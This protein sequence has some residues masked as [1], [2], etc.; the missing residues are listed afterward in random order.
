MKQNP[1]TK[2]FKLT[3]YTG[4]IGLWVLTTALSLSQDISESV[5]RYETT[6]SSI[7]AIQVSIAL[8]ILFIY[9]ALSFAAVTFAIYAHRITQSKE[10][11][12]YKDLASGL[13]L[14]IVGFIISA[15]LNA[16]SVANEELASETSFII[17]GNYA[18]ILVSIAIYW[19]FWRGSNKLL[20]TLKSVKG[21]A[22]KVMTGRVFILLASVIYTYLVFQNPYRT[23]SSDELI[24]PVFSLPDILIFLTIIIP[25]VVTWLL[26]I[27]ATVN[28]GYYAKNVQ[29]IIFKRLFK[30]IANG[31]ALIVGLSISLQIIG[32]FSSF[33]AG[34]GLNIILGV[35]SVIFIALVAAYAQ[36]GL[37]AKKLDRLETL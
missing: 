6:V 21:L 1:L 23:V 26:A 7:R 34:S 35:I 17:V 16:F 3:I 32:Q 8:P 13:M 27:T 18:S 19:F 33:W 22:K 37:A 30:N 28:I 4:M 10:G 25:Y 9:L 5:E 29:G 31:F 36:F 24:K 2:R 15:L 14:T 11:G 20:S 12:G